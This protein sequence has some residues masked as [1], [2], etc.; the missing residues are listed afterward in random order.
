M[1]AATLWEALELGRWYAQYPWAIDSLIYLVLFTG[2]ARVTV[3]QRFEGRGGTA[4]TVATG[5]ALTF[6]ATTTARQTHFSLAALGPL[7]WLLLLLVLGFSVF[8]LLRRCN[9][10]RTPAIGV[11]LVALAVTARALGPALNAWL[12]VIGLGLSVG[13]IG[14]IGLI[15]LLLWLV[16]RHGA[17]GSPQ[18]AS[19]E[20]RDLTAG[21]DAAWSAQT[22]MRTPLIETSILEHLERFAR[23][24]QTGGCDARSQAI[25]LDVQNRKRAVEQTYKAILRALAKLGWR[26]SKATQ[27]LT[28]EVRTALAAAQE[29][30]ELFRKALDVAVAAHDAGNIR[31]VL[32]ATQRMLLLEREAVKLARL[33]QRLLEQLQQSGRSQRVGGGG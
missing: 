29:N 7:A 18:R 1:S 14:A 32:E 22:G 20:E 3:G 8:D 21:Q 16:L 30:I 15:V 6:A 12:A 31:L 27:R 33:L 26:G 9:V 19:N 25:L 23:M 17:F 4:I 24:V 28:D 13:A 10:P 2:I 11:V 5:L